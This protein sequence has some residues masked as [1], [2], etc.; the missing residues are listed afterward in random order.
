VVAPPVVVT[1]ING[2][3]DF[4]KRN[5]CGAGTP[6]DGAVADTGISFNWLCD[7]INGGSSSITCKK[8]T[9][10]KVWLDNVNFEWSQN[11]V[12]NSSQQNVGYDSTDGSAT[13]S[14][15]TCP[16]SLNGQTLYRP[17][18]SGYTYYPDLASWNAAGG[19]GNGY[20]YMMAS[21]Y[22]YSS[23]SCEWYKAKCNGSRYVQATNIGTCG[24]VWCGD[25][26][27]ATDL[28]VATQAMKF[29]QGFCPVGWLCSNNTN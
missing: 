2:V 13:G 5:S 20:D 27:S 16:A 24:K 19:V 18:C 8:S 7:G 14:A 12:Y 4:T 11:T 1:P 15:G 10:A 25:A 3:C 17:Y 23:Y 22:I 28:I 21:G 26:S 29:T 9:F 6:N